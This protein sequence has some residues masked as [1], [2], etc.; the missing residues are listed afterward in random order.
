MITETA[1]NSQYKSIGYKWP[2]FA[3]DHSLA[4]RKLFPITVIQI[5]KIRVKLGALSARSGASQFFLF[6]RP[7]LTNQAVVFCA[8]SDGIILAAAGLPS[9]S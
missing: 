7:A 3:P 6:L 4:E 5:I 2:R 8:C 9:L 1:L